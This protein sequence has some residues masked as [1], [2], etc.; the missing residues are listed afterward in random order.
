MYYILWYMLYISL[1]HNPR[2]QSVIK[3]FSVL[4]IVLNCLYLHCP[5]LDLRGYCHVWDS[6]SL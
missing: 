5:T 2:K 4:F 6:L 3:A 1:S